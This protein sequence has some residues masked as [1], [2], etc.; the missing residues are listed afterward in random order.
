VLKLSEAELV[1][2][3]ARPAI[4]LAGERLLELRGPRFTAADPAGTGDA[5][6]AGMAVSLGRGDDLCE[7]P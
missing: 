4:A 1:A 5:M 2:E 7:R 3:G 6:V